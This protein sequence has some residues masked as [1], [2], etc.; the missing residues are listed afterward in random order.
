MISVNLHNQLDQCAVI[1]N[2]RT[3]ITQIEL[4]FTDF[5]SQVNNC[6]K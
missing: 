2:N 6:L 5:L 1:K 4:I 3:L